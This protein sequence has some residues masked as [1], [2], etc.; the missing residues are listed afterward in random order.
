MIQVVMPT[1]GSDGHI[2]YYCPHCYELISVDLN[3]GTHLKITKNRE[4]S[5]YID[6]CTNREHDTE[7]FVVVWKEYNV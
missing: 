2:A 1:I 6:A 3:D 4:W 5:C 7:P